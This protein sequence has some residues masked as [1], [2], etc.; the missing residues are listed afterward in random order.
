MQ[1]I[2][3]SDISFTNNCPSYGIYSAEC[4]FKLTF[5]GTVNTDS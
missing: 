3:N 5:F 4:N 2:S 1:V